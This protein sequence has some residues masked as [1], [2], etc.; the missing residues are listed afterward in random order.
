MSQ[1]HACEPAEDAPLVIDVRGLTKSFG[2]TKVVD[3]VDMQVA[4]GEI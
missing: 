1:T 3:N 2:G 4:E